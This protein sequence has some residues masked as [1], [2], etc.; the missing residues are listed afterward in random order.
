MDQPST[1]LWYSFFN[2]NWKGLGGFGLQLVGLTRLG[3]RAI[4]G[5]FWKNENGDAQL[6]FSFSNIPRYVIELNMKFF[7]LVFTQMFLQEGIKLLCRVYCIGFNDAKMLYK[8]QW[9]V[10][11]YVGVLVV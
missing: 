2:V 3:T 11:G 6:P 8:F 9:C 5:L 4:I 10:G 7:S 1:H